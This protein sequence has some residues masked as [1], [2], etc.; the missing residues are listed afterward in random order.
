MNVFAVNSSPRANGESK[1]EL[2]LNHLT[3]GMREAGATVEVVNLREKRIKR[4]H[5]CFAAMGNLL[6]KTCIAEGVTPKVF[7]QKKMIPRPDTLAAFMRIF[8]F[9][10]N[11][12]AAGERTVTLQF[13]FSGEVND[14]CYFSIRKEGVESQRGDADQPNITIET[15]FGVWMDILTGKADGQKLFMAQ[16]YTVTGDVALML[17]LLKRGDD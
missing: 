9:G 5:G 2:M 7:R 4:C 13:V 6:W 16:Q 10:L 12:D 11:R 15:P 17:Q 8:P 1:T 14:D 3:A